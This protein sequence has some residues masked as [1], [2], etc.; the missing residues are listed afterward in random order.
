MTK[1][2]DLAGLLKSRDGQYHAILSQDNP[3]PDSIGSGHALKMILSGN[4]IKSD[5]LYTG[6]VS[7]AQN[8]AMVKLLEFDLRDYA[9]EEIDF[10]PYHGFW[11]VD[12]QGGTVTAYKGGKIPEDKILGAIDHHKPTHQEWEFIDIRQGYGA[13]STI[14]AEYLKEL[15]LLR[16]E[17]P[18]STTIATALVLGILTDTKNFRNA[19]PLDYQAH[20]Y[21]LEYADNALIERIENQPISLVTART[22][23]KA[24]DNMKIEGTLALAGVGTIPREERDSIPEAADYLLRIEGVDSVV[25]YAMVDNTMQGSFR[26]ASD[27]VEPSEFLS[28]LGNDQKGIPFGGGKKDT[29]GFKIPLGFFTHAVEGEHAN[30]EARRQL[31]EVAQRTIES[32]YL[33]VPGNTT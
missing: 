15:G 30:E 6:R 29:G 12:N 14:F 32:L 20:E 28:K 7:H 18:E 33:T 21:L 13:T 27:K 25:V 1:A 24:I 10:S 19:C 8:R 3:D 26:T 9:R 2:E 16:K 17:N 22:I 5:F 31:W 11:M 23:A 4:G